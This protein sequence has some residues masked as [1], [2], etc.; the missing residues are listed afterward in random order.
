M[1][2]LIQLA[3]TSALITAGTF[4]VGSAATA[5]P[6]IHEPSQPSGFGHIDKGLACAFPVDIDLVSGD[7]GQ[8]FTFFDHDGNVL[9]QMGT[10]RPSVWRITNTD[11]GK[12]ATVDLPGGHQT[13]T[14]LPDGTVRVEISGG[15]IGFQ[16]PSDTPAGPFA[17][18]N[19]GR[20]VV[21]IATDGTGTLVKLTGKSFDL[22]AAVATSS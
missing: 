3:L 12:S 21:D 15:A 16:S 18:T 4:V 22:C 10:A 2:R 14:A 7:Q 13:V 5:V 6:P 17:F 9:R 19:V 8:L 11:T 20:L 1:K